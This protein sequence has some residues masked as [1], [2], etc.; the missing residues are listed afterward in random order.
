MNAK[1]MGAYLETVRASDERNLDA[2]WAIRLEM[3]HPV[4]VEDLEFQDRRSGADTQAQL[5]LGNVHS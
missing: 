1:L 4:V 3:K 2:G 5:N